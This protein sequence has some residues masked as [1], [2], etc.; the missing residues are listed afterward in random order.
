MKEFKWVLVLFVAIILF[1]FLNSLEFMLLNQWSNLYLQ[2]GIFVFV[3][4]VSILFPE[5]RVKLF[6]MGFGFLFLM[7]IS[8][9]FGFID[10]SNAFG[11]IGLGVLFL[12]TLTYLPEIVR[13]GNVQ[14]L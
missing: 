3:L 2:S 4:L 14:K 8:Y 7:F 5:L 9:L 11:S 10:A 1:V 12:N 13:N 6:Y